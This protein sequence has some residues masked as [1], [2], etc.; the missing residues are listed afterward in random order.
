MA[1]ASKTYNNIVVDGGWT[2]SDKKSS[3][4]NSKN[5]TEAKFLALSAQIEELKKG[6][7][8][9]TGT[10]SGSSEVSWRFVNK[11]NKKTLT[12]NDK[13]YNWCTKDCH[14]KPMWCGC[15]NYI[16]KDEF[17]N[18]MVAKRDS[19][20]DV[21]GLSA[22][23]KV[24]LA[25]VCSDEDYKSLEAQFLIKKQEAWKTRIYHHLIK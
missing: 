1:T 24:I 10:D 23:L 12:R 11:D 2:L 9:R 5:S 3:A 4:G 8:A 15:P 22:D 14:S 20:S 6:N 25:A 16:T 18:F 19:K 7:S 21:D 17:K 13:K